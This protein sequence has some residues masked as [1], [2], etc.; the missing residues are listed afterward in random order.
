MGKKATPHATGK[1]S[2]LTLFKGSNPLGGFDVEQW[3]IKRVGEQIEDGVCGETRT[4]KDFEITGYSLTVSLFNR[5]LEKLGKLLADQKDAD[6]IKPQDELTLGIVI[7]PKDGTKVAYKLVN[8]VF[9]D[10]QL[11]VGGQTQRIKVDLPMRF[12][13][14]EEVTL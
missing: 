13:D 2:F 5:D 4:R 9:D 1:N 8:G 6:D 10:W 7:K 11:A 3:T 14:L 12:D